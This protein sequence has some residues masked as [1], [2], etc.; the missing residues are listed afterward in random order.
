MTTILAFVVLAGGT[1]FA[2]GQLA[3][4]SVGKKQLK[5]NA[6]TTAKIKK[7]AVTKA[8]IKNGAVDAAKLADGSVNGA[9]VA[10]GSL[11]EGDINLGA[12]PFARIVYEARGSS[13]VAVTKTA[14]TAY[15]LSNG[16]YTQEAGRTDLF[17]G[18]GDVTFSPACTPPRTVTVIAFLDPP[19]PSKLT[20]FSNIVAAGTGADET[21]SRPTVRVSMGPYLGSSFQQAAAT[22]HSIVMGVQ[23]NCS[24]GDGATMTSGAI[25]VLGAK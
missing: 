13:S 20:S 23:L 7:N 12:T 15:P 11:T 19:D 9:K 2:A 25:D 21:G 17:T 8:K 6:V 24:A 22:N 3:K 18:A 10:D 14:I 4:N 5:A 16:T 1:A